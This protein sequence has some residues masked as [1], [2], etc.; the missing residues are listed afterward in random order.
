MQERAILDLIQKHDAKGLEEL[1]HR[2]GPLMRYI[3]AP[4][5]SDEREQE[6]C[7]S[8]V[9]MRIWEKIDQY[10]ES[11]GKLISWITAITRNVAINRAKK[12]RYC[13]NNEDALNNLSVHSL[14]RERVKAL[15]QELCYLKP[16][17]Q[18]IFYRKYFYLQSTS[19][20]A[21]EMGL[22]QRAVEGRLYRI[23]NKLKKRLGGEENV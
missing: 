14:R 13:L 5:L 11:R 4:I 8:D 10:D 9:L 12:N 15:K 2:Y 19:Q 16:S 17:D 18:Q 7:L 22:S 6:E 1:Q 20:I 21:M 23:R 3:I